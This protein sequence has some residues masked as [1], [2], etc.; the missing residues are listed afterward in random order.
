MTDT[1]PMPKHGWAC[2]HCGETFTTP[3]TAEDHFGAM[4]EARA[5]CLLKV[6]LGEERGL[7]MELRRVEQD[8]DEA[9]ARAAALR[10]GG[11]EHDAAARLQAS[12]Q[13]ISPKATT[14]EA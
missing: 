12:R 13:K 2:F 7:L 1:Y 10:V 11:D 14:P 8:R 4:P 3:G 5:G 6:A 9:L